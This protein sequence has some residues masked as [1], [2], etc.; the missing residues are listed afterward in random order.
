[1]NLQKDSPK[2]FMTEKYEV[3]PFVGKSYESN[4]RSVLSRILVQ[5]V[6]AVN[7]EKLFPKA[8]V[9]V[10][11]DDIIQATKPK[12]V[13]ATIIFSKVID[14]LFKQLTRSIEEMKQYLPARALKAEY[15]KMYWTEAPQHVNF[16]NNLLRRKI[17]SVV[18]ASADKYPNFKILKMKKFW[19]A[20]N[21]NLFR[22]NRFSGE[23][24]AKYW[25]SVDAAFQYNETW[26]NPF[27]PKEAEPSSV[28]QTSGRQIQ[29][30]PLDSQ[31]KLSSV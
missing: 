10:L 23:G 13:G 7:K 16:P 1:M 4:M 8:V 18:Q 24:L 28:S 12:E 17:N 2:Y 25:S 5:F 14:W 15:P 22:N 29:Q 31:K 9:L 21:T 19:D 26:R 11:D 27:K 3:I 30:I 6:K 20:E